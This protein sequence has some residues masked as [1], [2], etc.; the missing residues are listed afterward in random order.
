MALI[1]TDARAKVLYSCY[2]ETF[3]SLCYILL[4]RNVY[5]N[6]NPIY[7]FPEKEL[8]GLSPNYHM[9]FARC[10]FRAQKSIDFRGPPLPMA[11]ENDF[12]ASKSLCPAPYQQQ[13]HY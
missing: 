8:L 4:L 2:L 3:I 6:E 13:V 10:R 12:P 7:V 9:R 1:F 5:C 11:L